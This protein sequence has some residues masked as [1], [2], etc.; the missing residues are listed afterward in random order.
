MQQSE[1]SSIEY[2][3]CFLFGCWESSEIGKWMK[4]FWLPSK[5]GKVCLYILCLSVFYTDL[6]RVGTLHI[7][8]Y[9]K[10]ANQNKFLKF[11]SQY[12]SNVRILFLLPA[13]HFLHWIDSIVVQRHI[14]QWFE[15]WF[16][17]LL[18]PTLDTRNLSPF[19]PTTRSEQY[20]WIIVVEMP[21]TWAENGAVFLDIDSKV[22]SDLY[23][24]SAHLYMTCYNIVITFVIKMEFLPIRHW[25][26]SC[27]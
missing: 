15:V 12:L 14:M 20:R 3:S 22:S 9:I 18:A 13:E 11:K 25:T 26:F 6:V 16:K 10:C 23:A 27:R 21:V 8:M 24:M 1:L 2:W 5:S 7:H 17:D 19:I 4:D